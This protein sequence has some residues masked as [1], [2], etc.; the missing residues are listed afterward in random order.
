MSSRIHVTGGCFSLIKG[1]CRSA[2]Y[3]NRNN[4]IPF[5]HVFKCKYSVSIGLWVRVRRGGFSRLP[6]FHLS[7]SHPPLYLNKRALKSDRSH[8][9][10]LH[11]AASMVIPIPTPFFPLSSAC[12]CTACI[13][14]PSY[15]IASACSPRCVVPRII[16]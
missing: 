5:A 3:C 13:V 14:C 9:Q 4:A 11:R 8:P 6:A 15:V 7:P 2:R 10:K 12:V 1:K 16:V